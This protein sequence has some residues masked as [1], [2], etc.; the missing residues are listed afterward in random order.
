MF[1]KKE[2]KEKDTFKLMKKNIIQLEDAEENE[3]K[4]S[5]LISCHMMLTRMRNCNQPINIKEKL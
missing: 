1:P 2:K 3:A 5:I 4:M